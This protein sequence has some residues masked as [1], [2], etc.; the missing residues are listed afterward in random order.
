M[1]L[2]CEFFNSI[3]RWIEPQFND[4]RKAKEE[5][6]QNMKEDMDESTKV[7]KDE[8]DDD[9]D[10]DETGMQKKEDAEAVEVRDVSY[11]LE[12]LVT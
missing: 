6:D 7:K 4:G 3:I 2:F 5:K 1:I 12:P 10:E 8:D 9:D 11:N